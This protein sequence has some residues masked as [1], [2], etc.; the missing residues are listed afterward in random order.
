MTINFN[1]HHQPEVEQQ[2]PKTLPAQV[3]PTAVPHCALVEMGK[4][5]AV[6]AVVVVV[7]VVEDGILVVV[8]VDEMMELAAA[9]Q[10][11]NAD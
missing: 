8:V 1:T 10:R 11:P 9:P 4:L 2:L 3:N 5:D 7:V 6:A